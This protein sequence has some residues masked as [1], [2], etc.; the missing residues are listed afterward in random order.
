MVYFE[1]RSTSDYTYSAQGND[2][3]L[4]KNDTEGSGRGQS[5]YYSDIC[6][7]GLE[8][9]EKNLSHYS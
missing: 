2:N 4:I 8:K 9:A 7:Q 3:W 6:L 5:T 1:T